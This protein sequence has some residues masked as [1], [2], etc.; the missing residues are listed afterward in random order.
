MLTDHMK[1]VMASIEQ[2][3]FSAQDQIAEQIALAIDNAVW[4][5]QMRNPERLD[6]LRAMADEAI[7]D[8][9]LPF[10]EPVDAADEVRKLEDLQ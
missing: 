4:D 1:A 3:P 5:E 2:L 8:P 10:P 9:V 6:V 7:N